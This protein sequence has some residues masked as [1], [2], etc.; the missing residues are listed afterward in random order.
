MAKTQK[1][2]E[3]QLLE[4][5]I[6]YSKIEKKKIKATELAEWSRRNIEGLEEVR[7]YHFTRSIRERDAN[8]GKIIDRPKLCTLKINEINKA[9]DITKS[10]DTNLLLRAT[11]MDTF[12]QQSDSAQRKIVVETRKIFDEIIHRNI[13]LAR[14]NE[15][16]KMEKEIISVQITKMTEE[17]SVLEKEQDKLVK[18]VAY[19]MKYMDE[20]KRKEMLAKMGIEDEIIDLDIYMKSLE[21]KL[22]DVMD[23]DAVLKRCIK[24]EGKT[25]SESNLTKDI[26]SGINF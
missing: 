13:L 23:I 3:D 26:L 10:V 4:A 22:N 24:G 21:Q 19:I 8:T 15:A 5:V 7:D 6:K 2:S 12:F 25:Q 1:Y 14:E 9:R 20:A 16:L 17:I 11:N 18:Q